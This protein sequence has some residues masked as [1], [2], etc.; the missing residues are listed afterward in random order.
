MNIIVC[1]K[2]VP[3]EQDIR[4]NPDRTLDFARAEWKLS[5]YDLNAVEAGMQIAEA[6]G[7]QVTALSVGDGKLEN[8]KLKKAI[9]SRGPEVLYLV[10]DE[11]LSGADT[12]RTAQ[13]L[14]LAAEKIGFDLILCG[15]GSSDLY[16]RQTGIQLGEIL[17][18]PVINNISKI[19]PQNGL[20]LVERDLDDE[21]EVLEVSLPAVVSV[22]AGINSTRIP[23]M[24]DILNAGKKPATEWRAGDVG[25]PVYESKVSP[26]HTLA[27]E[28]TD[29]KRIILDGDSEE[30]IQALF[31]N[32]RQAIKQ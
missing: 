20:L 3:E 2:I 5:L 22:S 7:G 10:I 21:T 26:L 12:Y 28:Q 25:L 6:V 19:T 13:T 11:A 8:S 9:L 14:A 4:V 16:A 1:Y 27:P 15:E 24:K 29:R 17:Q 31:E 30:N 23:G 32:I 18:I